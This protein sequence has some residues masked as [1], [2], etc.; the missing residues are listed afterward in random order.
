MNPALVLKSALTRF[1][2]DG[3]G[4]LSVETVIL[5]PILLWALVATVV[6]FDAFR[7]R[8]HAQRAAVVVADA[9]SRHTAEFTPQYL[10]GMNNVYEL[11]SEA[12]RPTRLRVSSLR[13]SAEQNDYLVHWSYGTRGLPPLPGNTFERLRN[14]EYDLLVAQFGADAGFSFDSATA[15]APA[16]NLRDRLPPILP[17]ETLIL[18]ES[19]MLYSPFANVGLTNMR[20][21]MLVPTRPRFS[22]WVNLQGSDPA[23]SPGEI[24]EIQDPN[25]CG[26]NIAQVLSSAPL[27]MSG[28]RGHANARRVYAIPVS[29]EAS[30]PAWGQGS[31][32]DDS[33]LA[34]AAVHAGAAMAGFTSTVHVQIAPQG[35]PFVGS[36]RNGVTT[37]SKTSWPASYRF[38]RCDAQV[39]QWVQM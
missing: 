15:R 25:N 39:G 5:L 14:N 22:P 33:R 35:G 12:R 37:A 28:H 38:V 16:R 1:A 24:L 7:S 23:Y 30:G 8:N 3:R 10:E 26:G 13:W 27:D 20:F 11:L 36:T 34:V 2:R 21:D 18:V 29:G 17:G 32:S 9:I 19:F 6:F 31:Y 4:M